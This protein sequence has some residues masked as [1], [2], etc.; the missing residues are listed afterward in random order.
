LQKN[1]SKKTYDVNEIFDVCVELLHYWGDIVGLTYKEINV[2]I[3]VIIEPVIFIIMLVY[4]I[5]LRKKI[6]IL[7]NRNKT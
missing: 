5:H 6:K 2:W 3:F 1:T 7:R 4:I